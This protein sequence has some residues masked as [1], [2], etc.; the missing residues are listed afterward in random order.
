[1][2]CYQVTDVHIA[3]IAAKSINLDVLKF[4]NSLARA[5]VKSVNYRYNDKNHAVK[6]TKESFKN[7]YDLNLNDYELVKLIDCFIYQSCEV[8]TFYKSSVKKELNSIKNRLTYRIVSNSQH[9][10][11]AKW[12]I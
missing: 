2:S 11:I 3:A 8:D 10:N 1:M 5:N 4:A 7:A 9:Y 12:S 6:V